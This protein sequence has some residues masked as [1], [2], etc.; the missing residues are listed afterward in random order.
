VHVK[1][2]T[3]KNFSIDI[4]DSILEPPCSDTWR[5]FEK[6]SL[7][8]SYLKLIE[9]TKPSDLSFMYVIVHDGNGRHCANVYFQ[10]MKF[11]GKNI[12]LPNIVLSKLADLV[13]AIRPFRILICGNVFAVNFPPYCYD[14]SLIETKDLFEII[15]M[16]CTETRS[17]AV[18]IKDV[19]EEEAETN[20]VNHGFMNFSSDLTMS[21]KLRSNWSEFSDYV[22]DLS[23]KYRKR[24]EKIVA[25]AQP[26]V[27]RELTFD[28]IKQNKKLLFSL[29][30]NVSLKQTIC[31]GLINENYFVEFKQTFPD[32]FA[33]IGYYLNGEMIAFCS[34]IDRND[35]LEVHYIGMQ[36]ALNPHYNL[37]FNILFDSLKMAILSGKKELELGRTAREAKA[38]LGSTPI[39][40]ND[41]Y[42]IN[43]RLTQFAM[44]YLGGNFQRSMGNEW[45][46][47]NPFKSA[48]S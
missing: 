15:S 14:Q 29:F 23:K 26:I 25:S 46:K 12:H 17:D 19:Q 13:L 21:L 43:S 18:M 30:R 35:Q 1:Q 36:Y 45:Q 11:N 22:N 47:R 5:T 33:I 8:A 38:N 41:Y 10:Q 48:G 16:I 3:F 42:K 31:M 6:G 20:L 7:P 28:E 27:R 37:Y 24:A 32:T 40:F 4:Y 9:R 2:F 34:Y 39:Y 44:D